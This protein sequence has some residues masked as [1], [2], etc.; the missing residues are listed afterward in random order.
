MRTIIFKY[1]VTTVIAVS[2]VASTLLVSLPSTIA[3]NL[4]NRSHYHSC[5]IKETWIGTFEGNKICYKKSFNAQNVVLSHYD[6]DFVIIMVIDNKTKIT[7]VTVIDYKKEKETA[8]YFI[9]KDEYPGM[10]ERENKDTDWEI[11]TEYEDEIKSMFV[12]LSKIGA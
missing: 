1:L 12:A 2:S 11:I 7:M 4:T 6:Y 3:Q 8:I 9:D 5:L 10:M